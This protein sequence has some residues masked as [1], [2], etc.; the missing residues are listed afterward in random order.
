MN[1]DNLCRGN[2][3]IFLENAELHITYVI[4][5]GD[6]DDHDPLKNLWAEPKKV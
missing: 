4:G 3:V 5:W 6:N 1:P 2:V